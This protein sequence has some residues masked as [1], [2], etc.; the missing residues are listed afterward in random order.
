MEPTKM[1]GCGI[2]IAGTFFYAIADDLFGK[3]KESGSPSILQLLLSNAAVSLRHDI[4]LC[5]AARTFLV[6]QHLS[7][8]QV[9]ALSLRRKHKSIICAT[10]DRASLV[11]LVCKSIPC[12]LLRTPTLSIGGFV[13]GVICIGPRPN[14]CLPITST[15]LKYSELHAGVSSC[16]LAA[17]LSG[18]YYC[19]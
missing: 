10:L 12:S 14:H 3:K 1:A 19:T 6:L 13:V 11:L 8:D 7:R 18:I 5:P 4:A 16:V 2:A 15:T 9:R 17:D